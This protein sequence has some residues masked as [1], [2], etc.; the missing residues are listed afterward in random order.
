MS[1]RS[2]SLVGCETNV[3]AFEQPTSDPTVH[4][5]DSCTLFPSPK[6][7]AVVVGPLRAVCETA[8]NAAIPNVAAS[9]LF[10]TMPRTIQ[11]LLVLGQS[12]NNIQ[13]TYK[14]GG[15][16]DRKPGPI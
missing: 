6:V 12:L 13:L 3:R 5:F 1:G 10:N 8:I 4:S 7:D 11:L 16:E 9:T 15:E 14:G 2:V